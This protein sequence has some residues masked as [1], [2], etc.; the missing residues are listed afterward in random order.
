MKPWTETVMKIEAELSVPT[1]KAQLAHFNMSLPVDRTL[2]L[3]NTYRL[4]LSLTPRP[5]NAR[6]RYR[7]HGSLQH[8]KKLGSL[9]LLPAGEALQTKT[10]GCTSQASLL[11]Y[12]KPESLHQW[13]DDEL[14]WTHQRLDACLDIPE[15]NI[16]KVLLRLVAEL[17]HPGFASETMVELLI[18]QLSIELGRYCVSATDNLFTG[19]LAP[20][21]LRLIEER[22]R[23]LEEPPSL[24][25]LANLCGLSVRQMTRG[26]RDSRHCSIGDYISQHRINQAKQLLAG[27]M[28]I[29]AIA[30]TLGFSSS[31]SFCFAFRR[32]TNETPGQFRQRLRSAH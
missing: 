8:F 5:E 21:R 32:A 10:D 28:S 16:H 31:S 1:G 15:V 2:C 11:C 13:F 17:R 4:D 12:L 7:N 3:E 23:D 22:L 14:P 6:G 25:E 24:E 26:F 20:W 27:E 18:A 29:K 19:G 30:C 9:F